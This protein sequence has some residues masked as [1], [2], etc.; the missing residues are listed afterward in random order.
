MAVNKRV[1]KSVGWWKNL[2]LNK[3]THTYTQL[4]LALDYSDRELKNSILSKC[5]PIRPFTHPSI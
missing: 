4:T 2:V 1:Q 5:S 3:N